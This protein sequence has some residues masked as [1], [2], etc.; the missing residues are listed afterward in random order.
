MRTLVP[1]SA[2][3]RETTRPSTSHVAWLRATFAAIYY[4]LSTCNDSRVRCL[5]S[6]RA[7]AQLTLSQTEPGDI[8]EKA[9]LRTGGPLTVSHVT[10]AP[11]AIISTTIGS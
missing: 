9:A 2:R 10:R 5:H 3:S 11:L 1:G 4:C 8:T 6:D 7:F